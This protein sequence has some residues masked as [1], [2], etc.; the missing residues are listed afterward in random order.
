MTILYGMETDQRKLTR[1]TEMVLSGKFIP[2]TLSGNLPFSVIQ[3]ERQVSQSAL[4]KSCNNVQK[5]MYKS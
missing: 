2:K 4:S 1:V 3:K 5:T